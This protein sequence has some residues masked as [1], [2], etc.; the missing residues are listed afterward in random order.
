M[1]NY[2]IV[3]NVLL[4]G[5]IILAPLQN[6]LLAQPETTNPLEIE[7]DK[8][9]PVI[10][11]GYKKREL[12][13]FEINRIKREMD[14]LATNAKEELQQGKGDAAFELWYRQLR[15]AR[16]IGIETE[17]A[18]L[19][20]AGEIA[21][22]ANRGKD[23]RNIAN[24]LKTIESEIEIESTSDELLEQFAKAY[25]QVRYIEQ[26]IAIYQQILASNKARA[27]SAGVES[28]LKTLG[29]LY[30]AQFNY[31]EAAA[32]YEELLALAQSKSQVDSKIDSYLQTLVD[33]YDRTE[34]TKSAIATKKRLIQ[35]YI[36]AEKTT[37]L[38]S[39]ELAIALDYEALNHTQEAVAAY[40]RAFTLAS[41]EQQ[42]AISNDALEGLGKLY[43]QEGKNKKAIVTFN[44][45]LDVQRQSYNY[46]ALVD[47]YDTLGKIHLKSARKKQAKQYFQQALEIAKDLNYKVEY[48]SQKIKQSDR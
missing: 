17:I 40:E 30:L 34:Q 13:T 2:Q 36:A 5:S 24:R 12:S 21:W 38:A 45:L 26:A 22:Q 23:L 44:R 1:K 27:N 10:P 7:I 37:K 35:S 15:L 8:S 25:Q 46:Y 28:N 4:A 43:Q 33:I 48:F 31:L 41:A 18:A 42:L 47:T 32:T 14:R 3:F 20:E 19:G 39:I 6:N 9:D 11:L 16:A 29:E